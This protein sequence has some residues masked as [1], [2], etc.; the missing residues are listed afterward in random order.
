MK[1]ILGMIPT[2]TIVLLIIAGMFTAWGGYQT[3]L[4]RHVCA[5]FDAAEQIE[6]AEDLTPAR[7]AACEGKTVCFFGRL[8]VTDAPADPLT[9][10]TVPG[11]LALVRRTEMYQYSISG[12]SVITDFFDRQRP[13]VNGKNG[14]RYENPVFPA[15]LGGLTLLCGASV[16]PI[17]L[18]DAY[19][20]AFTAPY[21]YLTETP[22]FEDWAV[23][24]A[25]ANDYGLSPRDGYFTSGDPA[26]P[27]VGDLRLSYQVLPAERYGG[28]LFFFGKLSGGVLGGDGEAENAFLTDGC[29]TFAQAR[30][31]VAKEHRDNADGLYLAAAL[32]AL[33]AAAVFAV[34][35]LR[36][37][38]R[39]AAG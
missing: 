9:G 7:L 8:T 12:D 38:K 33:A 31:K 34:V 2:V 39:G 36:N 6:D 17:R 29:D 20:R 15:A 18:G 1:K 13:N 5:A 25:F 27:A 14:E 11:A 22:P 30:E 16:G 19:V 35:T 28:R 37:R 32:N 23:D 10:V 24:K 26:A 3:R 21:P 4:Y